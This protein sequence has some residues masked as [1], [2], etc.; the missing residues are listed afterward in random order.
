MRSD[1][2]KKRPEC[3]E[4]RFKLC[5]FQNS[6]IKQIERIA[7]VRYLKR[8]QYELLTGGGGGGGGG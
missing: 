3:L 7:E 8:L 5:S 4:E 2:F 6:L 1:G